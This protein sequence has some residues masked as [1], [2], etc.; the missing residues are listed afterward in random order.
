MHQVMQRHLGEVWLLGKDK[1][2][3]KR[4]LHGV[5]V[6]DQAKN[7]TIVVHLGEGHVQEAV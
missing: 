3:S 5:S 6:D 2:V 1:K 4:L 7:V